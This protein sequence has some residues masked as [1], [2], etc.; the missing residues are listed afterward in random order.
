VTVD[1]AVASKMHLRA[2]AEAEALC[3]LRSCRVDISYCIQINLRA[4]F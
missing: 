4:A 3:H 1:L 2:G